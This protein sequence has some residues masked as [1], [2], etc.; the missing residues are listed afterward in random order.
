MNFPPFST[1]A[2]S[3]YKTPTTPVT[4]TQSFNIPIH[5]PLFTKLFYT[6]LQSL[7][8]FTY[9]TLH[10]II[11]SPETKSISPS[12]LTQYFQSKH[13]EYSHDTEQDSQEF[14]RVLL[15]A[16]TEDLNKRVLNTLNLI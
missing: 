10:Q 9:Q 16:L 12:Q 2:K 6:E 15:A 8:S 4:S 14:C 3:V 13:K 5:T 11:S 7:P 1:K